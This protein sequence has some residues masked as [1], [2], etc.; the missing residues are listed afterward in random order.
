MNRWIFRLSP[1]ALGVALLI[2]VARA[3]I[4]EGC[5]NRT[6]KGD[7]AFR[8]SGEIFAPNLNT[9]PPTPTTIVLAYR[10]GVSLTHF[11]GTTDSQGK[12]GLAQKDFI[13][14][15]GAF[16]PNNPADLDEAG[17][18]T[19]ETGTY[20]VYSDCTGTA[21]I[22]FPSPPSGVPGTVIKL[23][24][25]IAEGGRKI[26]TIVSSLI[27]PGSSTS[28]FVNIH[29]DAERVRPILLLR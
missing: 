28:V 15:N 23:K 9:T 21:E 27:P 25:V 19:E 11:D 24:F 13:M 7:Y 29:S 3:Q 14:G 8:V 26:H 10:G 5:S 16:T 4:N 22:D 6:I 1:L 12:G 20:Q 18:N 17:F 2:P